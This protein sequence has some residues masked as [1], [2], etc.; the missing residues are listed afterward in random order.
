MA[1]I[2]PTRV[3]ELN[4]KKY[5]RWDAL[6]PYEWEPGSNVFVAVSPPGMGIAE[7]PALVRGERGFTPTIQSDVVLNELDY[8][9]PTVA[10]ATFDVVSP[11]TSTT[12]P[13][14]KLN[15]SLHSGTPGV[16]G[17]FNILEAEDF[18]GVLVAKKMLVVNDSANGVTLATQK[19]GDMKWPAAITSAPPGSSG[20]V[21]LAQIAVSSNTY[22]FAVRPHIEAG[23]QVVADGPDCKVDIVARLNGIGGTVIGRG[24]GIA[25]ESDRLVLINGCDA[26]ASVSANKIAANTAFTVYINAEQQSGSDTFET[27]SER[28]SVTLVAVT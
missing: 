24:Y 8:N 16:S 21:N 10:S 28:I 5:L 6:I 12:P 18:A 22:D 2:D 3:F 25:G 23:C 26:G 20:T 15:L 19:V 1:V 27:N 4:G 13:V 11:G 17:T 14:L 9:D 7:I